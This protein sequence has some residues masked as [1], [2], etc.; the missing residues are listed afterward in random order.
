MKY[1]EFMEELKTWMYDSGH[2]EEFWE[3]SIRLFDGCLSFKKRRSMKIQ[4]TK[5][6]LKQYRARV[7][8]LDYLFNEYDVPSIKSQSLKWVN[9]ETDLESRFNDKKAKPNKKYRWPMIPTNKSMTSKDWRLQLMLKFYNSL[10]EPFKSYWLTGMLFTPNNGCMLANNFKSTAERV[11]QN[12]PQIDDELSPV[13][14]KS[15]RLSKRITLDLD[16]DPNALNA[17]KVEII[18]VD[19]DDETNDNT[20]DNDNNIGNEIEN[21]VETPVYNNDMGNEATYQRDIDANISVDVDIE[22]NAAIDET[23]DYTDNNAANVDMDDDND[24]NN[25]NNDETFEFAELNPESK[26][27]VQPLSSIAQSN[28]QLIQDNASSENTPA[29]ISYDNENGFENFSPKNNDSNIPQINENKEESNE[30]NETLSPQDYMKQAF[31]KFQSRKDANES[32]SMDINSNENESK[33]IPNN[34][35]IDSPNESI[36][37]VNDVPSEAKVIEVPQEQQILKPEPTK[38]THKIKTES[39]DIIPE[40]PDK[41]RRF[42]E[43]I[44]KSD[45]TDMDDDPPTPPTGLSINVTSKTINNNTNDDDND[46]PTPVDDIVT[47]KADVP[48]ALFIETDNGFKTKNVSSYDEEKLQRV[49]NKGIHDQK[50]PSKFL[51]NLYNMGGQNDM[52]SPFSPAL[53]P[54]HNI[55]AGPQTFETLALKQFNSNLTATSNV[56][57]VTSNTDTSFDNNNDDDSDDDEFDLE[58]DFRKSNDNNNKKPNHVHTF[59]K[60]YIKT[61]KNVSIMRYQDII[62]QSHSIVKGAS[63]TILSNNSND[64]RGRRES[65]YG[66]E[67]F[68][69]RKRGISQNSDS[70]NNINPDRRASVQWGQNLNKMQKKKKKGMFRKMFNWAN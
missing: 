14:R 70:S 22:M 20:N 28:T 42:L 40:P 11:Y 27:V 50:T 9:I 30:N 56:S 62:D 1:S 53:S 26:I 65:K 19:I 21:E 41:K 31:Q 67:T 15:K 23:Y 45:E 64:F 61:N 44:M 3:K 52:F 51:N 34:K 57:N 36:P 69:K 37:E 24:N 43:A 49:S 5:T 66:Y 48:Q 8:M 47:P 7:D 59:S 68:Q 55:T 63:P 12:G 16:A 60:N 4:D 39:E 29:K 10:N 58:S 32:K 35:A 33:N 6:Y 13:K 54:F 18:E 25:D 46:E 2:W 38:K 17:K